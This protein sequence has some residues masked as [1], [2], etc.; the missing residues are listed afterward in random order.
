MTQIARTALLATA[1]LGALG[2]GA[3]GADAATVS[4][5][6][7]CYF[8]EPTGRQAIA[9]RATGFAPGAPLAVAVDGRPASTTATA[10]PTGAASFKLTAPAIR[11]NQRRATLRV[12]DGA[13]TATASFYVTRVRAHFLPSRTRQPATFEVRFH[14][15]G[16][17]AVLAAQGRSSHA[18]AYIHWQRPNGRL[19]ATRRLGRLSG[20]CGSLHAKRR[21]G[22]PFPIEYGR[23][24]MRFDT[25]RHYSPA[26]APQVAAGLLVRRVR[27]HR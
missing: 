3:A 12:G 4:V 8:S 26:T 14:V 18:S 27:V 20:P 7:R 13:S 15:Y 17:G 1:G 19:A 9:V 11:G 24:W 25:R 5:D 21:R 6:H 2:A 10:D 23:W 16:L 22:L